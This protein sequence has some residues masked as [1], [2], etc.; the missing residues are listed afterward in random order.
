VSGFTPITES[1]ARQG[2][3]GAE[4]LSEILSDY[5]GSLTGLVERNGGDVLFF[6]GDAAVAL[7]RSA[8]EARDDAA[9]SAVA[10]G[11]EIRRVLDGFT[12][13]PAVGLEL[14]LRAMVG[15][16]ALSAL[17]LGV[18]RRLTL[19][20]GAPFRQIARLSGLK[21]GRGVV[22]SPEVHALVGDV[23]TYVRGGAVTALGRVPPVRPLPAL[24]SYPDPARVERALP[25]VV[26]ERI[27]AGQ[28]DF[29]A[30]FRTVSVVFVGLFHGAE[31]A[32][33]AD[34][35]AGVAAIEEL[36]TR[37]D[38]AVY[39][40]LEDDKGLNLVVSFGIP[41]RVH[42]DDAA[43]AALFA[44]ATG[45]LGKPGRESAIGV[46]TGRVFCG[47]YGGATRKQYSLVGPTIN[48]AARLMQAARKHGVL[49]DDATRKAAERHAV[50]E[51]VGALSLKG[52]DEA[53]VAHRPLADTQS[54]R[55]TTRPP[56]VLVGRDEQR[57]SLSR[58]VVASRAGERVD[59]VLLEAEA[60]MGKSH[61]VG[62]LRALSGAEG[63]RCIQRDADALETKT[64]YYA[65][66]TVLRDLFGLEELDA[67][68]ARERVVEELSSVRELV[69]LSPLLS[70]VLPLDWVETALTQQMTPQIRAENLTRL[71]VHLVSAAA[72]R[73]P[74]L[75]VLEDGHWLDSASWALVAHLRRLVSRVTVVITARPMD[76]AP[77]EYAKLREGAT[78]LTLPAMNREQTIRILEG[79]FAV[80]PLPA[81]L[82][83]FVVARA[84]GNPFYIEEIA[85]S[86]RDAGRVRVKGGKLVAEGGWN[87]LKEV[88][89]PDSLA[90][91]ITSRIDRLA[92]AEQL[93]LKVAS[94]V[95]RHF[96]EAAVRAALP[97]S[98][99][100]EHLP[101]VLL[102]LEQLDLLG[103]EHDASFTF[104]HAL[105]RE[106]TYGLLS[107]SQRRSLHRAVAEHLERVHAADPSPVYARL[108]HHFSLAEDSAK[109][110]VAFGNAG[111]QSLGAYANEEAISF[112][113]RALE[114]HD[115]ARSKEG[116]QR[117]AASG[118]KLQKARWLKLLGDAHYSLAG[119]E[120]ARTAYETALRAVGFG[121]PSGATGALAEF[122]RHLARRFKTRLTGP[123]RAASGEERDRILHA[124]QTVSELGAVLL[125]KGERT[126]FLESAFM[127]RNMADSVGPCGEAAAAMSGAAFVLSMMG[128][129]GLAERDL[130]VAVAL[131]EEDPALLPKIQALV[132]QGMFLSLTGR[133][134]A[135]LP[136]LRRAGDL[137]DELGG[138]LWKHRAKFMLGEPLVLLG[139]YDEAARAFGEAAIHSI[140]AEPTVVGF[141]Y[142][143]QAL[144]RLRLGEID[145]ALALLE[146]PSGI[147][148]I[149]PTTVPLQLFS[150]L[151]PLA[152]ARLAN[153]DREGA[154]RAVHEA[155]AIAPG[156]E[157][158]GYFAG[159]HGHAAAC[160]VYL[161]LSEDAAA[162]KRSTASAAATLA[163][164]RRAVARFRKFSRTFPGA[165]ASYLVTEGRLAAQT[166]N[167]RKG[168]RILQRSASVA[169]HQK[170]P[171]EQAMAHHYLSVWSAGEASL[172]HARRAAELFERFGM[173]RNLPRNQ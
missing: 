18:G 170:M 79:R 1:F 171:Y 49:C 102:R 160:T 154:L 25:P 22:V 75:L 153:G 135:A 73:E 116:G 4:I 163:K 114:L 14:S 152:E 134:E 97:V 98:E 72:E 52:L 74:L 10:C 34:L 108:A 67:S 60:G 41:P 47:A 8:G 29:L 141:S 159:I 32:S 109:A 147:E 120:K 15:T 68:R 26:V 37:Y 3:R 55:V 87:A 112:L 11:L 59:P 110:M 137:A 133:P 63:L 24:E 164:A 155:E 165:I 168:V 58:L 54:R 142:A 105:T 56:N 95:G 162:G 33:L 46:A 19:V 12:A 91:V 148:M 16:G 123:P 89:F 103:R 81:E 84:E 78:L 43:R 76:H 144:S 130:R 88:S 145:E 143:M 127:H 36:V 50:F 128:M 113:S 62:V 100:R 38:G 17:R 172:D 161:T 2:P 65:F 20:T 167:V 69:P 129:H 35:H 57:E 28:G 96:D 122:S 48:R 92:A 27:Y 83:D 66:R 64:P 139:A 86:L 136:P 131:A 80:S 151:G 30:E 23:A 117:G 5:Y 39:Q 77:A 118:A 53:V 140:G 99:D 169:E 45:D 93:V 51:P 94:V 7:F 90:A 106:T 9:R 173:K 31:R 124:M 101:R 21:A 126:K 42:E 107:Y 138:G 158:N 6:A 156:E 149:R 132:M 71:L 82:V 166:G 104:R 85:L 44:A 157:A 121:A 61:M 40:F 125:W 111:E 13:R 150:S 119:H 115:A 146:G 70:V